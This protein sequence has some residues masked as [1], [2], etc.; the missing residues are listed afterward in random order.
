[1]T[2]TIRHRPAPTKH[3]MDCACGVSCGR[4]IASWRAHRDDLLILHPGADTRTELAA[5]ADAIREIGQA[6]ARILQ[7][8]P[9]VVQ[10]FGGALAADLRRSNEARTRRL[11]TEQLAFLNRPVVT[12]PTVGDVMKRITDA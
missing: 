7:N 5:M 9:R 8:G 1:M 3:G 11:R 2:T 10:A 4:D 12:M 6:Y